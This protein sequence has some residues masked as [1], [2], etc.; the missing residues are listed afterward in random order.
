MEDK[1][2]SE[3]ISL[4]MRELLEYAKSRSEAELEADVDEF[5]VHLRNVCRS[6][7]A[8]WNE[9]KLPLLTAGVYVS[10]DICSVK[11]GR[12]DMFSRIG[13]ETKSINISY[14]AILAFQYMR[15]MS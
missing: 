3:S 15:A 9:Y 7:S 12:R 1:Y 6:I 8:L 4:N 10:V 13:C 11:T 14:L 2:T 5:M